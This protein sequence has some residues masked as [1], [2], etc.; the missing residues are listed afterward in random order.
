[1]GETNEQNGFSVTLDKIELTDK[2]TRVWL[3]VKNAS[4]YKVSLYDFSAKI[5]QGGKQLEP[6]YISNK[7]LELPSEYLQNVSAKG[8]IVFPAVNETGNVKF[9]IDA[10]YAQDVPFELYSSM[11]F[12]EIS[13]EV[14]L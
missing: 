1:V 6:K 10:P 3:S 5:V 12:K 9:V 4:N 13:F 8:V 11:K 2:Q 7:D 14:E